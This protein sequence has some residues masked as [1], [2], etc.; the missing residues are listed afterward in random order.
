MFYSTVKFFSKQFY[1][2]EIVLFS[3]TTTNLAIIGCE[4]GG[5]KMHFFMSPTLTDFNFGEGGSNDGKQPR[6]E[7]RN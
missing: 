4:E 2:E 1:G 3:H 7:M 6:V 5:Y